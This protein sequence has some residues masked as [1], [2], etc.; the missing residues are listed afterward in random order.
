MENHLMNGHRLSF[1]LVVTLLYA[2]QL[3]A[4]TTALFPVVPKS[5]RGNS[6]YERKG[7]HDAN[8]I[9]TE[10]WN[11]GMVGNYPSDPLNVDLT[12]FHSMEVPKGSGVN[13]SDG[14]TPFV[15]SHITDLDGV[16]SYIMETGYRERQAI[17]SNGQQMRFEPRPGYFQPDVSINQALSPAIS[18]D[19]RTWPET[20]PDKDHAWDGAWDGYFGKRPAADEESFTVMDDDYYD[21]WKRYFPDSRDPTRRGLGMRVEVRGF[22]WA[23]PQSEDVIFWHYDI[24]N[25]GTTDYPASG[26]KEN[27]IFGLYM[28]SGVGGEAISCDGIA[29]SDDDNAYWDRSYAGLNLVY[30]WDLY[31]HGVGLGTKCAPTGYLGYAYLETPGKPYDGVDNDDDGITDESRASGPGQLIEG[32]ANIAAYANAHYNMAKFEA[33]YGKLE[34]RPAFKAG[35]WWTGDENMNWVAEYDDYGADGLPHTGDIGEGD[36]IPTDGET[37]FDKTDAD[38]SDQIGLTG[39][40]MNRIAAGKGNPST[41]TDNIIFY[42]DPQNW[43]Q[44]LYEQFTNPIVANRFDNA[45]A[46]NYNIGFLFASGPFTLKA[47]DRQRFSLALAFGANLIDLRTTISVVQAIYNANYQF[48]TP[49]PTPTVKA[50]VGDGYVQLTWDDVAERGTNPIVG[51]DAFEGY[52]IYRSTDP[53]FLDPKVILNGQGTNTLGHG[54]ALAQFDL[55]DGKAGYTSTSVQGISYWLGSETGLTHSYRDTAVTNG[56]LYYYAVCSYDWGPVLSRGTSN[57]TYYPSESALNVTRTLRGG[58]VL[59][60]NVIIARPNPK[61][62]GYSPADVSSTAHVSGGGY[63]TVGVKTIQSA[64]VPDGHVF[65]ISFL[66]DPDSVHADAYVLKDS[67][68]GETLF[69]TGNIFDGSMNG[70]VGGGILPIVYTPSTVLIDS[71]TGWAAGSATN[72][73]LDVQYKTVGGLPINYRRAGFPNDISI[74]FSNTVVDTSAGYFPVYDAVPTKFTVIAHSASGDRKLKFLFLD[75]DGDNTLSHQG[76]GSHE[77]I[78]ILTGTD[79]IPTSRRITWTVQMVNDNASTVNPTLGDVFDLRLDR[80]FSTGDVFTFTSKAQVVSN[81]AAKQEFQQPYVVPNPYVGAASFE[82]NPFGIQ[83]R[84]DRR[85]EFRSVPRGCTI[86]IFTIHGDLVQTLHQDGSTNGFVPWDLRTKD[87]L[88]VAPGLYIYHV[89]GGAAGTYIGKFAIIK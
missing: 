71:A 60:K 67:T 72:A 26:E 35:R 5:L 49:P 14:T 6:L 31:G 20:W 58:T 48:S 63:G 69:S 18:N 82:P 55:I 10:F 4:Q 86:R 36:G 43:P 15:L 61:I 77:A 32:Q 59:P 24:A 52:K 57:F 17:R 65:S 25:E 38:E 74:I 28:D 51:Y 13:Y 8:N 45:V 81:E 41:V 1:V 88:D 50:E 23:N 37:N 83:G 64:D 22:Q 66:N 21:S 54:R 29:E 79:S 73:S 68:T 39:F 89:D 40:K 33:Y 84:G 42:T 85:L 9:R 44:R 12:T 27:I 7:M 87:N 30:T 16:E 19:P 3:S 34:D 62:L 70:Q 53:D 11:Y 76:G 47:G 2:G 46:A 78:Q 56:Q 80:P 75:L